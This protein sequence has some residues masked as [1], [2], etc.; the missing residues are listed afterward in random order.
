MTGHPVIAQR[1]AYSLTKM[2]GTLFFQ[3]LAQDVPP[4]KV[5]VISFHPGMIYGDGWKA[6]GLGPDL[7]DTGKTCM[8][9][10]FVSKVSD[11]HDEP[12]CVP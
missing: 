4:E 3:L 1:P 2:A 7:F 5:Q 8:L 9:F 12:P 10:F 6:I 11:V